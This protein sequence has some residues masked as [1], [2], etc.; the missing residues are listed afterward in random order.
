MHFASALY[1]PTF[2]PSEILCILSVEELQVVE[3]DC[4]Y[5]TATGLQWVKC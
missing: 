4:D 2:S 3:V 5:S 1:H